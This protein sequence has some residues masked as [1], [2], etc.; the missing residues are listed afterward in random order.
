MVYYLKIFLWS[1]H[2]SKLFVMM[3]LDSWLHFKLNLNLK[4]PRQM[5]VTFFR[6]LIFTYYIDLDN[7]HKID[8]YIHLDIDHYICHTL[9]LN[10]PHMDL[11][12]RFD[13]N[14]Y[15]C[16]HKSRLIFRFISTG[17]LFGIKQVIFQIIISVTTI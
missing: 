5:S 9:I 14:L 1:N 11:N 10:S 17:I 6:T 8:F 12:I 4:F 13:I 16:L 3:G 15:I 2:I 7:R